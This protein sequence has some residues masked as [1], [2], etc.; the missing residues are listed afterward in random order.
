MYGQYELFVTDF[1]VVNQSCLFFLDYPAKAVESTGIHSGPVFPGV[2]EGETYNNV[3]SF[4]DILELPGTNTAIPGW[5][6]AYLSREMVC[7]PKEADEDNLL[8]AA[9]LSLGRNGIIQMYTV[10]GMELGDALMSFLDV[11]EKPAC[12]TG[13]QLLSID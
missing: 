7:E 8:N 2:L 10:C 6:M 1:F 11:F 9:A 3:N 5:R 4:L 12:S 13:T